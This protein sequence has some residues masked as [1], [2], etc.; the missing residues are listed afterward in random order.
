MWYRIS[1]QLVSNEKN[2]I[3]YEQD[4]SKRE[5]RKRFK[6]RKRE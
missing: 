1:L 2:Q 3:D 6:K 4:E 5:K